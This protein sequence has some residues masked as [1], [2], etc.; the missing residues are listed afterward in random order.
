MRNPQQIVDHI[1]ADAGLAED[2]ELLPFLRYEVQRKAIFIRVLDAQLEIPERMVERLK[3]SA[4]SHGYEVRFTG[5]YATMADLELAVGNISWVWRN[6]LPKEMISMLAGEP[7]TG[8]SILALWLCKLV[9][10]GMVLPDGQRTEAGRVIYIDAEAAQV[11]TKERCKSMGIDPSAVYVPNLDNNMLSQPDLSEENH[12]TQLTNMVEDIKPSLIVIDSMGGV[13]SG[14][15]NRKEDMQPIMLYLTQL[16][17]NRQTG[18]LVIH[19]L[20]KTKRE[21]GE[22]IALGNLRG[23]TVISQFTR[24]VM[25]MSRK[26]QGIKLWVGKTNIALPPAPLKVLPETEEGEFGTM[27]TG[28]DFE[29]W[30]DEVRMTKLEECATWVQARL[31]AQIDNQE[32]SHDIFEAGDETWTKR[33][34]KDAGAMLERKGIIIRTGGR[35]SVW[36]LVQPRLH[37]ENHNGQRRI[38]PGGSEIHLSGEEGGSSEFG[39]EG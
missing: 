3:R 11:I 15:E 8:K 22:E 25:F 17:Q 24:S 14:G 36:R 1:V 32:V 33:T 29:P 37:E 23:S 34:I 7:G 31:G 4:E 10:E 2:R 19:H 6:W 9:A 30:E 21:E 39:T 16:V 26:P 20:N 5:K 28:F 27:I 38:G 12:R 18:M 35:H 13:K